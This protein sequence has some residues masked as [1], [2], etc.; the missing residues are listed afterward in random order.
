VISAEA[1][2]TKVWLRMRAS[3]CW[4]IPLAILA[5]CAHSQFESAAHQRDAQPAMAAASGVTRADGGR[6]LTEYRVIPL[7]PMSGDVEILYGDPDA[8]G[9][10]FVMRIRELAGT[11]VPPHSHPVDEHITVVRGTWYF[12]L[13][14]TFDAGALR[15]L[16]AGAYAFAPRGSW[17][18]GY[19]PDEA[20]VQVHGVG[21]FQ[22]H[23]H[24]GVKTLDDSDASSTF[25]H[26]RGDR[27]TSPR[28]NGVI[29]EGYASGK[30]IQ[31]EIEESTR[32][33]FMAHEHEVR[34]Q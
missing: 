33:R 12:G 16:K 21:P 17:M 23:W 4:T 9:Q 24:D 30:L 10:P 3:A 25:R 11:V 34:L 20:I 1:A 18:F 28:G 31:Y 27:V 26:K 32:G 15:E 6:G 7:R 22:I 8:I 13:G 5:G 14:E 2:G 19:S 29:V